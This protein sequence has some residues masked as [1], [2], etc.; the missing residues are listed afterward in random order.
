MDGSSKDGLPKKSGLEWIAFLRRHYPDQVQGFLL[1][2]GNR[3][4]HP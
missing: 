4:R 1:S 3:P 2:P